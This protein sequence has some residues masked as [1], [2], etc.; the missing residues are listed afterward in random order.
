M[1]LSLDSLIILVL[2]LVV[3]LVFLSYQ[4][5]L[6]EFQNLKEKDK[7]VVSKKEAEG[8][9]EEARSLSE[10]IIRNS[11]T[12]AQSIVGEAELFSTKIKDI[13]D[14]QVKNTIIRQSQVYESALDESRREI[15][16]TIS[17]VS[18][19]VRSQALAD[20]DQFKKS[21]EQETNLAREVVKNNVNEE[22]K[23]YEKEMEEYKKTRMLQVE[24]TINVIVR[25]VVKKVLGRS[26]TASDHSDLISAA[27]K[28]AKTK[29]VL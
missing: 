14:E 12:K 9:L 19:Q 25:D 13:F 20:I 15:I 24:E 4:K 27:L 11:E 2:A 26:L 7:L 23:S 8:I 5:L 29:N 18:K 16:D 21:L 10:E 28:E 3:F 17:D 22:F 6:K 1:P